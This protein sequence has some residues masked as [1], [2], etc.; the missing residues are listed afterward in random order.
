LAVVK[1]ALFSTSLQ[2]ALISN[3]SYITGLAM[4][5]VANNNTKIALKVLNCILLFEALE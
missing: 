1:V 2:L 4:A 5:I 3:L